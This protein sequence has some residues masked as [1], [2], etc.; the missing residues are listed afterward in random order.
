MCTVMYVCAARIHRKCQCIWVC[1]KQ[2]K[3]YATWWIT[4]RMWGY[5]NAYGHV[6]SQLTVFGASAAAVVCRNPQAV[7]VRA[8]LALDCPWSSLGDQSSL[9]HEPAPHR[10]TQKQTQTHKHEHQH[11]KARPAA[12]SGRVGSQ[13]AERLGN[14]SINEKVAGSIPGHDKWRYVLGLGI[15]P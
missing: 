7:V 4:N 9:C 3:G 8:P 13:M 1:K 10:H 2:L 11:E 12:M 6:C 5:G 14:R 15:S